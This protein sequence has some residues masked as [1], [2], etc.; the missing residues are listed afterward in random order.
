MSL[1]SWLR[2]RCRRAFRPAD[3]PP[4]PP[5]L[6]VEELEPRRLL[7]STAWAGSEAVGVYDLVAGNTPVSAKALA[8]PNVDGI[9]LRSQWQTLEP[10]DGV[11]DWSY[12]DGQIAAATAAGKSVSLSVTAGIFSPSWLYDE[13]AQAFTFVGR[14]SPDPQTIPVPYDPVFL[15]KWQAFVQAFGRRYDS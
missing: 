5:R 6:R 11:Y 8:N 2:A 12:F 15:E 10:A 13:G 7:T 1:A 14:K 3:A 4:R 9:A